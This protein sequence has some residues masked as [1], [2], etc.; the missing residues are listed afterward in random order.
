MKNTP[1]IYLFISIFFILATMSASAQLINSG[2]FTYGDW[3]SDRNFSGGSTYRPNVSVANTDDDPLYSSERFGN[4]DYT[5]KIGNGNYSVN[6]KFAEIWWGSHGGGVGSRVFN[7]TMEGQQVLS[8]FDILTKVP[9]MTAYDQSFLVEV[10]D[11]ILNINFRTVK[12]NAKIS[13]IN[14]TKLN[15]IISPIINQ[16]NETNESSNEG[17]LSIC[18]YDFKT[19]FTAW[20]YND[21]PSPFNPYYKVNPTQY[22]VV[23]YCIDGDTCDVR[24]VNGTLFTVRLGR[25]DTPELPSASAIA[26]RDFTRSVL[27]NKFVLL[28]SGPYRDVDDTQWKR[29]LRYVYFEESNGVL[30]MFNELVVRS[31]HA[32]PNAYGNNTRYDYLILEAREKYLS[33]GICI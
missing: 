1:K 8:N 12:D 31:G 17:N 3:Q 9:Q 32:M 7:V 23:E 25:V 28:E 27:M 14:V 26:A 5:F 30:R 6:L 21:Y 15:N 10:T 18:S 2:G 13:A 20:G 4:F 19:N 11:G 24:M 33:G 22:V 16:T 29:K